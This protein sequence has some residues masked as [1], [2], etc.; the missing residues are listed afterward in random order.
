MWRV[1]PIT[2]FLDSP[3]FDPETKRVMDVAF[4]MA[5]AA[6]QL[7]DQGNLINERIAKRIIELA[8]TGEA[9]PNRLCECVVE[10]ISPALVDERRRKRSPC[11]YGWPQPKSACKLR[12]VWSRTI[13]LISSAP[14]VR[15]AISSCARSRTHAPGICRCIARF[16]SSRSPLRM[17]KIS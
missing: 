16:A 1:M 7:G 17:A 3:E 9:D 2:Q 14:G 5:R 4:E 11:R 13:P 15:P 10:G 6:L 12:P 8:K